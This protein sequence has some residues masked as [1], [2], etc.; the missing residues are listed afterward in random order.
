MDTKRL[1]MLQMQS[2]HSRCRF[3]M[4]YFVSVFL[5]GFI[6]VVFICNRVYSNLVYL[7]FLALF[8]YFVVNFN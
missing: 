8:H 7:L 5:Y 3:Y 2:L 6:Y 1:S 4:I